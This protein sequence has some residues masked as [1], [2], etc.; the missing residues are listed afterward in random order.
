MENNA[1]LIE[2]LF[3]KVVEYSKT[4]YDLA[5]LRTL[6]KT[7][8]IVS[9]F[10]PHSIVFFII[11]SFVFFFNFGLAFWIGEIL[12]K[13]YYGFFVI[14]TFYVVL[15]II[16]RFFIYKWIKRIVSDF[17]IKQMLK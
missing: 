6:D 16:I 10:I 5:K 7:S 9:S 1:K 2:S 12:G 11:V 3:E 8:D 4:S 17:F 15:F 14:A 13:I